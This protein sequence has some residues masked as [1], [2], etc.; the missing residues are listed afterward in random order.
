MD[1]RVI[2]LIAPFDHWLIVLESLKVLQGYDRI[3]IGHDTPVD[4][5]AIDSKPFRGEGRR[6]H[7][8]L[9][10]AVRSQNWMLP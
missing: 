5:V 7:G 8:R 6:D 9:L 1:K 10:E 4:R 3:I 2:C